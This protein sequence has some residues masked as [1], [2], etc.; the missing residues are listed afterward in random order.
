MSPET[1][2]AI[3]ERFREKLIDVEQEARES[4][5]LAMNSYGAGYDRGFADAI[6]EV[7]SEFED[8]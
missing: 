5:K 8:F 4:H 6:R 7:L 1:I 2:K 3:L